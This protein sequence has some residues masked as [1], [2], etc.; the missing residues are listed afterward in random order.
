MCIVEI[1]TPLV[2]LLPSTPNCGLKDTFSK[3]NLGLIYLSIYFI[4]AQQMTTL[5]GICVRI[6]GPQDQDRVGIARVSLQSFFFLLLLYSI[7]AANRSES[8]S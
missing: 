7:S 6:L 5:M 3:V 8:G 4:L 1:H 2:Q